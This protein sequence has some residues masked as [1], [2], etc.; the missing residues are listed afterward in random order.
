M[1]CLTIP[2]EWLNAVKPCGTSSLFRS[3]TKLRNVLLVSTTQSQTTRSDMIMRCHNLNDYIVVHSEEHFQNSWRI[4][5]N[6]EKGLM[7]FYTK[8]FIPPLFLVWILSLVGPWIRMLQLNS[9]K[10]SLRRFLRNGY[11]YSPACSSYAKSNST[12]SFQ[13]LRFFLSFPSPILTSAQG[14]H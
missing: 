4:E 11:T 14:I 5:D 9:L 3:L 8:S 12:K 7:S 1:Y 10:C 2:V 6:H 13:S